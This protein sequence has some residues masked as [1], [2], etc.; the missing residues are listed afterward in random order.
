VNLDSPLDPERKDRRSWR[1]D[2]EANRDTTVNMTEVT[3][4][5]AV[6]GIVKSTGTNG[7]PQAAGIGIRDQKS[8]ANLFARVSTDGKFEFQNPG[9]QPGKYDLT[10]LNTPR[11]FVAHVAAIGAKVSGRSIEIASGQPVQLTVEVATGMGRV[12]GVAL[13]DGKPAGGIM[14]MLVPEDSENES[15]LLRRDQSDSDGTFSLTAVPGRYT[16]V[17]VENGWDKEWASPSVMKKWLKAGEP[18][19]VAPDGKYTIKVKVQ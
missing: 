5:V 9:V 13:R 1:Q 6:S 4:T 16:L 8:G 12:E 19:E 15:P 14:I 11:F 2:I 10:I 3:S 17:A 18:V 7:L